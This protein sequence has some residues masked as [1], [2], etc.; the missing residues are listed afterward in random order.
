MK[1]ILIKINDEL[2]SMCDVRNMS[3][4]TKQCIKLICHPLF[5]SHT[6]GRREICDNV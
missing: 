5:K 1:E 6:W 3:Y 2:I 4:M